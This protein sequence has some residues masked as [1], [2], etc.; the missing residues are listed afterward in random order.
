MIEPV[1][2]SEKVDVAVEAASFFDR[3]SP[4]QYLEE[5]VQRLAQ[6][7]ERV[8]QD[9]LS[10]VIFRLH[11]EYLAVQARGLVEVTLP[12]PIHA[13]PHRTSEVVLGLVNIR[14]QLRICVSAHGLLGIAAPAA[15]QPSRPH[16]VPLAEQVA[17][18][19]QR[20]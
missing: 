14:G 16:E 17:T 11:D 20:C 1:A 10:L 13:I 9:L 6:P 4:P 2:P 3:Q 15:S 12:Q 19:Q 7:E 8:E 5:W 18:S